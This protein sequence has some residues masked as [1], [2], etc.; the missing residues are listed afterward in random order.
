LPA[1]PTKK[2]GKL[3]RQIGRKEQIK[4]QKDRANFL[5][6]RK[7][8]GLGLPLIINYPRE[9]WNLGRGTPLNQTSWREFFTYWIGN[10]KEEG[11]LKLRSES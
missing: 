9:R 2:K 7:A 1:S 8:S 6:E 3:A 5:D 11:L 10:T 4:L